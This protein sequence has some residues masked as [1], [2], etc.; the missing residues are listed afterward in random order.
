V[1]LLFVISAF[2][3]ME[4]IDNVLKNRI[5]ENYS[6]AVENVAAISIILIPIACLNV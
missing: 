3:V 5:G 6:Q 4:P 1:S 2:L